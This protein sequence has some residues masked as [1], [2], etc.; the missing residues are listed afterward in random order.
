MKTARGQVKQEY[1]IPGGLDAYYS[2]MCKPG[3]LLLAGELHR[4]TQVVYDYR[5]GKAIY[6]Y[7][8]SKAK[9]VTLVHMYMCW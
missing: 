8:S 9:E 5:D 6:R 2:K 4:R 3:Q 7:N 1:F